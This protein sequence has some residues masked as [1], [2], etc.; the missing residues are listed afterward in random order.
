MFFKAV[1]FDLDG[2]LLDT[3]SDLGDSMNSVLERHGF[4]SHDLESYKYMI[5]DGVEALV[6]RALPESINDEDSVIK[7]IAEYRS[8][9]KKNWNNKTGPYAG[10]VELIESLHSLGLKIAVFS[11]KPHDSTE[12][13][14]REFLP[15]DKF[16]IVLGHRPEK[17]LKPDPGGALEIAEQLNIPPDQILY[18]GDTSVDMKTAVAAGMYPVGVLWGFRTESELLE[19]GAKELINRPAELLR[20]IR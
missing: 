16:D 1:I 15:F 14:V 7:F 17:D 4:P 8:E 18:L 19:S 3:L 20:I 5:G 10:I 6:K 13:C 12:I 11:N 2:T 9:Y